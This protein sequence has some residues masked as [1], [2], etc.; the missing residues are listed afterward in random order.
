LDLRHVHAVDGLQRLER[1]FVYKRGTPGMLSISDHLHG[2]DTKRFE[3]TFVSRAEP[4]MTRRGL[5]L[6]RDGRTLRVVV[7]AS[8]SSMATLNK[9]PRMRAPR[10]GMGCKVRTAAIPAGTARIH[11]AAERPNSRMRALRGTC[12]ALP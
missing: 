8:A 4:A 6:Q 11:N 2:T 9:S 10:L 3:S 12:S 5:V 1:R 7:Q